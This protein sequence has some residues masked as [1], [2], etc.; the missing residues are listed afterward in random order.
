MEWTTRTRRFG[1][2]L[3][4]GLAAPTVFFL[5]KVILGGFN[6]NQST[7]GY[8]HDLFSVFLLFAVCGELIA[9]GIG[10]PIYSFVKKVT[11]M[12]V[13]TYVIGGGAVALAAMALFF[14]FGWRVFLGGYSLRNTSFLAILFVLAGSCS[15]LVWFFLDCQP[16]DK[17]LRY[18]NRQD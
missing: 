11:A 18:M 1:R 9:V 4:S 13:M 7:F 10:Y 6:R 14:S 3:V 5:V 8:V 15:G 17:H 2:Y 12:T 16:D